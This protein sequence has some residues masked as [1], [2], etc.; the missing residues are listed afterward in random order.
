MASLPRL[1]SFWIVLATAAACTP[2]VRPG[3][4]L[5]SSASARTPLA[6]PLGGASGATTSGAGSEPTPVASPLGDPG[7]WTAGV[8]KRAAGRGNVATLTALRFAKHDG[9]DRVV[10]EFDGNGL[11]ARHVEYVDRPVRR[12]GSGDP[13]ELAGDAW[14]SV[15]FE[16]A[17]AHSESG[18]GTLAF[19]ETRAELPVLRELE[20]TCDFEAQVTVVFGVSR[21]NRYRLLELTAPPRFVVDVRH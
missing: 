2:K 7:D 12:C 16:P 9:F 10:F 1:C 5:Q 4:S 11:P 14:L 15:S 20:V 3:A 17:S 13:T 19:R 8:V 18:V 21:P 6:L